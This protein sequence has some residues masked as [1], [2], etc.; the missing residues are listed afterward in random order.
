MA[1]TYK[2]V[3]S[4]L[5]A[6]IQEGSLSNIIETIHWRYQAE[7]ADTNVADAYGSVGLEA[8]DPD[9]FIRIE[10]LRQS[11]IE[12]WLEAHLDVEELKTGLDAQLD[13]IKNPT[14]ITLSI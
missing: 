10:D 13:A 9:N 1:N 7:D 11:D 3:V 5:D 8:P 6:K 14:H 2:W 12:S 4:S